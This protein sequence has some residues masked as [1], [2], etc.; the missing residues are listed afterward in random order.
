LLKEVHITKPLNTDIYLIANC[1]SLPK[2]RFGGD[3]KLWESTLPISK[4]CTVPAFSRF[5][6]YVKEFGTEGRIQQADL[7]NK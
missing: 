4:R 7:H 3:V 5:W 2:G 6:M 1:N